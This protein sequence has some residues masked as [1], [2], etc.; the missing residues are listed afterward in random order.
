MLS[1]QH[2]F[3]AGNF[4]DVQKH[5]VLCQILQAL[6]IKSK[7]WSY[8]ETHSGR[9]IY[10][11]KDEQ[12]QKTHEAETGI[13]KLWTAGTLSEPLQHYMAQVAQVNNK[14]ELLRYP[15]SPTIAAQHARDN[16]RL[17]LME[18]H[19][20]E[21]EILKSWFHQDKRVAVHHRDGYEGVM[22]QLPP[23]PRRG[24]VVID[25]S[26]EVKAEYDQVCSFI[27]KA[28]HRW[29]QGIDAIWY[30]LLAADRWRHML[31]K[32]K[33]QGGVGMLQCEIEV[34]EPQERGMYGSGM[35]IVNPPWQLDKQLEL[36]MPELVQQ[37]A[38]KGGSWRV[39]WLVDAD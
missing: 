22:S 20:S 32:L 7:P 30:P 21:V 36:L 33:A 5:L 2:G 29:P 1:Y 16:D 24:L 10:D 25:P 28:R 38:P 11:L 35:L 13:E 9:A 37:L 23:D 8:L 6:N 34:S 18:L 31:N 15:G 26:Y 4:A 17:Y 14:S 12:A 3:H 19:P 27:Q 39:N